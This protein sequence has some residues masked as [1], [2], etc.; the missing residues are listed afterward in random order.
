MLDEVLPS[1]E[2]VSNNIL[3]DYNYDTVMD[4]DYLQRVYNEVLRIEPPTTF[5][6]PQ[7]FSQDTTIRSKDLKIDL[8]AG[9]RFLIA[10]DAVHHDPYQWPE[11]N[12][13]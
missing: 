4:F 13:F 9:Q 8:K 2:R 7:T 5:S 1:V 10:F 12:E 3:D 11:P 6:L